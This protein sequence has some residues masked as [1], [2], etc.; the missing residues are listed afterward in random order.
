MAKYWPNFIITE[1]SH[2]K[3]LQRNL[4]LK[5]RIKIDFGDWINYS[6]ENR[7]RR[8]RMIL[9]DFQGNQYPKSNE[10]DEYGEYSWFKAE[11]KGS[12]H[13]GLEFFQDTDIYFIERFENNLWDY[14]NLNSINENVVAVGKVGRINFSD[15]IV[16]DIKGDEYHNYPH[17]YCKF[18]YKGLP[19]ENFYYYNV[20]RSYETYELEDKRSTKPI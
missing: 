4:Q 9:R 8:S 19:F 2:E 7:K 16:Y 1:N 15:I 11:I 13:N 20:K 6:F 12:Y 3:Q 14:R 18:K 17:I 5:S 10:P